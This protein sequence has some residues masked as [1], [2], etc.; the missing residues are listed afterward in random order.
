MG[1]TAVEFHTGLPDPLDHA[2]R[3][4]R[5]AQRQG[6]RV[7]V[8]A[9]ADVLAELDSRLWTFDV[10]SF[11]P[12]VRM[13]LADEVGADAAGA[14]GA[15][16]ARTPIWLS[17]AVPVAAC[18]S[19]LVNIGAAIPAQPARF[20]RL[21]EIVGQEVDQAQAG[22]E[23]WRAYKAQ[24]LDIVHHKPVPSAHTQPAHHAE[25]VGEADG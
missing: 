6:V 24:G 8:T 17:S 4:L 20:E 10:T 16:L 23:R 22:R 7:L 14:S 25:G 19:V 21:I 11:V 9:P 12:H 15:D 3:L 13:S 5:K 18:P 2:C 1:T